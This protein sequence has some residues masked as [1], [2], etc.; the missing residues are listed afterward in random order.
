MTFAICMIQT[1]EQRRW[2]FATHP[3]YSHGRNQTKAGE[4]GKTH[5]NKIDPREVDKYVDRALN[6]EK[7]PV[8]DLLRIV[9]KNFGTEGDSSEKKISGMSAYTDDVVDMKLQY[10]ENSFMRSALKDPVKA[11]LQWIDM[12]YRTNPTLIDPN[13]LES[14]HALPK[15]FVEY[16]LKCNLK[17]KDF[18]IIMRAAD[19]RLKPEGVHTG[20]GRGGDWN[21]ELR[22]FMNTYPASDSEEHRDRIKNKLREMTKE[23]GLDKKGILPP[24]ISDR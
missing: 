11:F 15:E 10:P 8:A 7:G 18:L 22:R 2:W 4:G 21:T 13:K 20:K 1:E 6:Y 9:K 24:A 14:H 19:H 16:F 12:F 23:Y 5:Q 17:I 3:E